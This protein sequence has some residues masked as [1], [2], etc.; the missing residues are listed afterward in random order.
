MA[1]PLQL[2]GSGGGAEDRGSTHGVICAVEMTD[3]T[4][5]GPSAAGPQLKLNELN[6]LNKLNEKKRISA[7]G[8]NV[9]GHDERSTLILT[10]E[11]RGNGEEGDSR[12]AQ[13]LRC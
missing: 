2:L 1:G 11:N 3:S 12:S 6:G 10:G 5:S 7:S 4:T 8:V 9:E 13:A